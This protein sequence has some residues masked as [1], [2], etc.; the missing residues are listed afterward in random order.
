[1]RAQ[2]N[3]RA[4]RVRAAERELFPML[5][6]ERFGN[7]EVTVK[8]VRRAETSRDPEGQARTDVA[9]G[10]ANGRTKNETEAKRDADHAESAGTFFFR[11]DIS[12]VSHGGRNTRSRES[13]ND[14]AE[15]KPANRRGERHYNVIQTEPEVGKQDH[16][17]PAE[18]VGQNAEDG[19]AEKLHQGED[20]A[21]NPVPDGG[22]VHVAAAK[23]EDQFRQHRRDQAEREHVEHDR[24][25][26]EGN[27]G[28]A[29]FHS[30]KTKLSETTL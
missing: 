12:D 1:M 2:Q 22:R 23:V 5:G 19:R 29:R 28:L 24:D 11:R 21:E 8:P 3:E 4:D 17:A 18:F 27:C 15:K 10:T 6:G 20:G 30:S 14:P 25:E 7:E 16:R 9:E 26:D 13:R